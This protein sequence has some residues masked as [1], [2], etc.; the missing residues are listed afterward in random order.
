MSTYYLAATDE[1]T[2]LAYFCK[3]QSYFLTFLK[4]DK[5]TYVHQAYGKLSMKTKARIS[6]A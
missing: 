6:H 4:N 1:F 5:D 3:L 2:K